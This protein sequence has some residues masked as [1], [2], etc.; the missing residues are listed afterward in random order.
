MN[1][2]NYI[3]TGLDFVIIK[4]YTFQISLSS[5]KTC[6]TA[7]CGVS[8]SNTRSAHFDCLKMEEL[9]KSLYSKKNQFFPSVM[10]INM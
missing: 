4:T 8:L 5:K 1:N 10:Q 6:I 3:R 2:I 9:L 7:N